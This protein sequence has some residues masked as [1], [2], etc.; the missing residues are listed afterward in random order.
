MTEVHDRLNFG[1]ME[2]A[3]SFAFEAIYSARSVFK[4]EYS[5]PNGKAQSMKKESALLSQDHD[6]C[7]IVSNGCWHGLATMG[8]GF[9]VHVAV[10]YDKKKV[11]NFLSFSEPFSA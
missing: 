3:K 10:P 1:A 4:S 7:C 8:I 5:D 6:A 11:F 9:C 2:A